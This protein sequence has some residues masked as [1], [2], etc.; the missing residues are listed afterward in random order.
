MLLGDKLVRVEHLL[1]LIESS[2]KMNHNLVK[3]DVLPKDRQNFA[4]CQKISSEAVFVGLRSIEE[5]RKQLV[6]ISKYVFQELVPA[7]EKLCIL[8]ALQ[9]IRNIQIAFIDKQ[10]SY[11]DRIQYAWKTVF[12]TR[13]WYIWL[14]S[15]TINELD[16][17]LIDSFSL[18]VNR[19]RNTKQQYFM[20]L[21]T[22]FSIEINNSHTLVYLALLVIQHH[23]P[24]D[25]VA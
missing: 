5:S 9:M 3:S 12:L 10:T 18:N 21:A 25:L 24:A 14:S 17:I 2:S 19:K 16:S 23:L 13:V 20:T 6:C 7:I 8:F 11:I 15:K 4:S 22:M 1:E